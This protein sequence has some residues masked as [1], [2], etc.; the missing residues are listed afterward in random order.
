MQKVNYHRNHQSLDWLGL[1]SSLICAIHCIITPLIF[2]FF[3]S[4]GASQTIFHNWEHLN[5]V[6]L[7]LAPCL[8]SVSLKNGYRKHNSKLPA[9][10]FSFG[11]LVLLFGYS[12]DH[13]LN[14][15]KPTLHP[16][17]M[18]LGGLTIAT[19]HLLNLQLLKNKSWQTLTTNACQNVYCKY[20]H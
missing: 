4:L 19:A 1:F 11:F 18:V 12:L 3:L 20:Y 9:Y 13:G 5:L 6:C 7:I 10:I 8:A 17:F 14:L 15:L 2:S 16:I